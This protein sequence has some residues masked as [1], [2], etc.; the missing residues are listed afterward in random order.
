MIVMIDGNCHGPAERKREM[1]DIADKL[2]VANDHLVFGVPDPHIERWLLDQS[3]LQT[4]VRAD[5][6]VDAPEYKCERDLYKRRLREALNGVGISPLAGGVE[7]A[8]TIMQHVDLMKPGCGDS[9]IPEFADGLRR[10][11]R[12][13][14]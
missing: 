5:I 1:L 3:A 2:G 6:R 10:L 9:Q 14:A 7:Y 4:V 8:A 12:R 11:C 13:L